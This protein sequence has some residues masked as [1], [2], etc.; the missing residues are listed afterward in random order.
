[1]NAMENSE[2]FLGAAFL[3]IAAVDLLRRD[4]LGFAVLGIAGALMLLDSKLNL[5]KGVEIVLAVVFGVLVLARLVM[6]FS[7]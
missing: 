6:L 1:M 2:K 3:I 7:R 5:P 4:W